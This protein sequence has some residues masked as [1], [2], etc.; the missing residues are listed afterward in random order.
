MK[1]FQL[2][3][4]LMWAPLLILALWAFLFYA[5]SQDIAELKKSGLKTELEKI[6]YGE[7]KH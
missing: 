6:W 7:Q 1:K 3:L 4:S 5:L 2:F